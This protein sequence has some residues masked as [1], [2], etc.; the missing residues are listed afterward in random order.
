MNFRQLEPIEIGIQGGE[1]EGKEAE[2]TEEADIKISPSSTLSA[3]ASAPSL[4]DIA[5]MEEFFH[6][7]FSKN[8]MAY[9]IGLL[10]ENV[11]S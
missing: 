7:K 2:E 9:T 10:K 11:A 1:V 3:L 8:R 5:P 6:V 4:P